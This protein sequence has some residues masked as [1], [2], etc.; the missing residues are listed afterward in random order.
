MKNCIDCHEE[1]TPENQSRH[2]PTLRCTSCFAAFADGVEAVL[3]GKATSARE[4]AKLAL[5][6]RK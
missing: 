3:C 2:Q 4:A 5:E 6:K 1:L